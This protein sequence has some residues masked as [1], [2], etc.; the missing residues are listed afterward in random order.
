MKKIFD[1]P[2]NLL[3]AASIVIFLQLVSSVVYFYI[4]ATIYR[5]T[6]RQ[7]TD[8]GSYVYIPY[9]IAVCVISLVLAVKKRER[10]WFPWLSVYFLTEILFFITI[11]L[12]YDDMDGF[13]DI[14]YNLSA[15]QPLYR[16]YLC[17]FSILAIYCALFFSKKKKSYL[18]FAGVN[19]LLLCL[20]MIFM[21]DMEYLFIDGG[22]ILEL[23]VVI[24]GREIG[25]LIFALNM[26]VFAFR[27]FYDCTEK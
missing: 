21:P 11:I 10:K 18:V 8:W 2:H 27:E 19:L 17:A 25:I 23:A 6:S 1:K 26:F 3:F 16:L 4:Q 5:I 20:V 14:A 15:N 13:S 9:C 7:V 24:T 22:G 12:Q